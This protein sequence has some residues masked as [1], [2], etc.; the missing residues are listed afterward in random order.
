MYQTYLCIVYIANSDEDTLFKALRYMQYALF[1]TVFHCLCYA[2]SY[3]ASG[4][5]KLTDDDHKDKKQLVAAL[6]GFQKAAQ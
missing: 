4:I 5:I 3:T 6:E 2:V 1:S